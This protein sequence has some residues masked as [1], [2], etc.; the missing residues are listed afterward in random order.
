MTTPTDALHHAITLHRSGRLAEADAAYAA[1]LEREPRQPRVLRLRG[2]LARETGDFAGSLGLLRGAVELAPADAESAAELGLSYLAAG[3]LQLAEGAF[4][5]ALGC[6]PGSVKAL[7]NLGAVLQYRGHLAAAIDC[8]RRVLALD[9][10]DAE[11]RA[12]LASTLV[13][14]GRGEEALAELAEGLAMAPG[15]PSLRVTHGAVLVGLAR[16]TEALPLLESAL[17]TGTADD[18]VLVNIALA[19]SLTGDGEGARQALARALRINPDN[20]RATADLAILLSADGRPDEGAALCAGFIARHPGERMV[21]AAWGHA[22]CEAGRADEAQALLDFERLVA[23][24]E[25]PPPRGFGSVEGFNAALSRAVLADPSLVP[26][27]LSKATRQGS[28]SGELNPDRDPALAGLQ[29]GLRSAVTAVAERWRR[30]P[31]AGH[32]AMAWATDD[33]TLRIWTTVLGPGGHQLPHIHPLAWLSG[34]YY[35][36]LPAGMTQHDPAAGALE[37][38]QMPA[39]VPCRVSP[40]VRQVR[41]AEGRLVVF[42]SYFHHRTIAY[43]TPGERISIAFDVV[44]ARQVH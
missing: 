19:R 20:A 44:P 21:L 1:V 30:G 2:I 27:P 33:Y 13:E 17:R 10:D 8:Y 32:P 3:Y 43:T 31:L 5:R 38:G 11:M 14:V 26:A 4:R 15:E 41:P 23:P 28:Q 24:Q 39:R 6:D 7:A 37:F 42:A 16:Y 34:V 25:L 9:P 36:A 29:D 40:P 18:L 22:L 12:N 35:V